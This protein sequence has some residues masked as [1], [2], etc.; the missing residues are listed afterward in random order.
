MFAKW[1]DTQD[2]ASWDQLL[3]ALRSQSVQEISL[4][5]QIEDM[6]GNTNENYNNYCKSHEVS[7]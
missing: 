6:L 5:N 3:E 1:L 2:G 4:A 7:C